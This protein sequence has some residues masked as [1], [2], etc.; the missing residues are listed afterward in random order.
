MTKKRPN[1]QDQDPDV[2]DRYQEFKKRVTRHWETKIQV[3]RTTNCVD[4]QFEYPVWIPMF[5]VVVVTVSTGRVTGWCKLK[6]DLSAAG[7]C[8]LCR[9]MRTKPKLILLD[10]HLLFG[11]CY[12]HLWS[13]RRL[14]MITGLDLDSSRQGPWLRHH[15]DRLCSHGATWLVKRLLNNAKEPVDTTD[16]GTEFQSFTVLILK[17]CLQFS[18]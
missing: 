12:D 11:R 18:L 9:R 13:H 7:I 15:T 10:C 16:W 2:Q 17:D 14:P 8:W 4:V 5:T 3:S 1:N 6:N